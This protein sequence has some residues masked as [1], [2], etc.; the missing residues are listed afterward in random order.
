MKLILNIGIVPLIFCVVCIAQNSTNQTA[1]DSQAEGAIGFQCPTG[2]SNQ[3]RPNIKIRLGDVTKKALELPPPVYPRTARSARI[4]GVVKS[5]VVINI[6]TGEVVWART[7]NGHD[8][9][10]D[11]VRGAVCRARFVPLNDADGYVSGIITYRFG[12]RK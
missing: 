6:N 10:Q 5:E 11:A 12:R 1:E 8:L 9:L 7:L 3:L 4:S 2:N